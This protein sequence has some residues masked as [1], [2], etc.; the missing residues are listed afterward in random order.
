MMLFGRPVR[1]L[2]QLIHLFIWF[3][4]MGC[5]N[6]MNV[7]TS[8]THLLFLSAIVEDIKFGEALTDSADGNTEPSLF[9]QEGV[10]TRRYPRK[11]KV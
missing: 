11:V 7:L 6:V 10:E 3:S 4:E 1:L 8:L 2:S 5:Y 9:I